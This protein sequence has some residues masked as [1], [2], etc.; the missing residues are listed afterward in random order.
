MLMMVFYALNLEHAY[1]D[2]NKLYD[3][4]TSSR[5]E[6][7]LSKTKMTIFGYNKRKINQ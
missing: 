3:F 5:F 2:F 7:N 4:C 6:V 1:K